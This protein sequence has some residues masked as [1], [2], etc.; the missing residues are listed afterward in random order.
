MKEELAIAEPNL[1]LT[2][3]Q[4]E[5]PQQTFTLECTQKVINLLNVL[6]NGV[7]RNSDVIK[8]VVESSLSI[9]VLKTLEDKI[10][11]TILIRSLIESG[12]EYVEETLTS[13]AKLTGA[14]VEFSGSYPGWKPVNDTAILTLMKNHYTEV[15]G[16]EPVIKVIHAGLECGLLK[17]HYPNI[18]MISVGPTIRNA[19]S[20]DEKVQISTVQT[21][22]ELLTKV[23]AN[24][25]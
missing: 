16:K 23:L 20:P 2:V 18:D 22:W 9:G 14:T 21:Y 19:H 24:I 12:K 10:E 1:T 5:N 15:L 11:G 6:P 13:L 17:E 8:N 3:E 4:V 25:K 7:I